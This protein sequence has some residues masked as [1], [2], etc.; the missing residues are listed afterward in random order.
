MSNCI[1]FIWRTVHPSPCCYVGNVITD[2][3][4]AEFSEPYVYGTDNEDAATLLGLRIG[5]DEIGTV[6]FGDRFD[7]TALVQKTNLENNVLVPVYYQ[8]DSNGN[9][10]QRTDSD[11]NPIYIV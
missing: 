5:A 8:L 7:D 10:I 11:G 3:V 4:D 1:P 2:Q 9:R 6:I